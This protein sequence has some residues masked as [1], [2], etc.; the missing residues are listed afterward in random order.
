MLCLFEVCVGRI[1]VSLEIGSEVLWF[2]WVDVKLGENIIFFEVMFDM[3]F[4]VY[5]YMML[6]QFYGKVENDLFIWFYG[7]IL[8]NVEDLAIYF[9]LEIKV[10]E[11]FCLK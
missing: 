7:V 1:L 3:A 8:V 10:V 5:V 9:K 2:F 6:L 4:I 11:E